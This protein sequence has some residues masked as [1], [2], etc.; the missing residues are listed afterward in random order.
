[1]V[2]HLG[3]HNIL[4]SWPYIGL[5]LENKYPYFKFSVAT[6]A[7]AREVNKNNLLGGQ[8]LIFLPKIVGKWLTGWAAFNFE[9]PYPK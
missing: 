2:G 1:M 3:Q 6:M 8:F 5:P 4:F 9:R 7:M